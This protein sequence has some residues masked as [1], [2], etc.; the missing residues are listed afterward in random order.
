MR[1]MN[2]TLNLGTTPLDPSHSTTTTATQTVEVVEEVER[3]R[4]LVE[5]QERELE[6]LRHQLTTTPIAT[7]STPADR[8]QGEGQPA[9]TQ[10]PT[11]VGSQVDTGRESPE[12]TSDSEGAGGGGSSGTGVSGF[13]MVAPPGS[14]TEEEAPECS[15]EESVDDLLADG[16]DV[17]ADRAQ[18]TPDDSI[19]DHLTQILE[20]Q[21]VSEVGQGPEGVS[22]ESPIPAPSP[23]KPPGQQ[24]GGELAGQCLDSMVAEARRLL[25]TSSKRNTPAALEE[26]V[27]QA[28]L[29]TAAGRGG[30]MVVEALGG[31]GG[32]DLAGVVARTLP[33]IAP[34]VILAKRQ[35][36]VALVVA[37]AGQAGE[38]QREALVALL[39]GLLRRP[40]EEQRGAVLAGLAALARVLG[41]SP[42]GG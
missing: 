5:A 27:L 15:P 21:G 28:G 34:N 6:K 39:F 23:A 30:A 42:P 20:P 19:S 38:A 25:R 16:A 2:R 31:W 9:T 14:P 11:S 29:R 41:P 8:T 37:G 35:E 17:G 26:R 7:A 10:S 12:G 40:D 22:V 32:V 33:R 3:L 1:M 24:G 18:I 4:I 13:V 36:V